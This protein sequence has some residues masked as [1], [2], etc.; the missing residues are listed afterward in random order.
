MAASVS[1]KD[2]AAA[3]GVSVG[4]VSNVLNRPDRVG[5]ATRSR[6]ES[7]IERLG[8]V[9]NE[10]AR[11]LR[12]G[13]SRTIGYLVLDA[14]NPFFTDVARGVEE[15]ARDA[16]LAVF[17]CNSDN[18]RQREHEY[19]ELLFEQRVRGVL[20]TPVNP[21]GV[22]ASL[23]PG[24]GVPV[25]LVD[26]TGGE[27]YCSVSVDDV[28]GGRLAG[29]YLR[30]SGHE[31]IAFVGGPESVGQ[32]Q[33]RL[34]GFQE[35]VQGAEPSVLPTAALTVAEGRAAGQRL[36]GMPA[37]RRPTAA[38]CANDLLALGLLQEMTRLRIRVPEDLAIVGYD[39]I[40][41]AAAAAVP[42]T[43][44]RQP[45]HQI[46][47]TAAELLAEETEAAEGAGRVHRHRQV[48]YLP[49]LIVRESTIRS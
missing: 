17:L 44:V 45:R 16:G 30:E 26:R 12:A 14:A 48:V 27:K 34:A 36:A 5:A 46:G 35:A 24:V 23:P 4:T 29:Q 47:R 15:A 18:S 49:E 42:L 28:Y 32:V 37:S 20:V 6:V 21:A 9:R 3:A 43:S 41:F 39:D 33:D 19:L 1:V 2:V 11:H 22:D 7:A 8:F 40:E 10:S 25:V 31:R 13:A 38:F